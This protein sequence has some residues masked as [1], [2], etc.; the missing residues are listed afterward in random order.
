MAELIILSFDGIGQAEYE[1][2]N[3]ELGLDMSDPDADWPAGLKMHAGGT[4]DD[5][6]FVVTEVWAS[7]EAQET[8]MH[9]RLGAALAAGGVTVR[10]EITWASLLEYRTPNR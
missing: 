10:P 2:V 1:A 7:R 4:S 8:F 5:G 3:K 9:E 6:K